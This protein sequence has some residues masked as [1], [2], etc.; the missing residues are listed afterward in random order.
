MTFEVEVAGRARQVTVEPLGTT[1]GSGGRFRVLLDGVAH[2]VDAR[3]TDLGWSIVYGDEQRSVDVAVTEQPRGQVLVQFPHIDVAVG[4]DGRR[5]RGDPL[6]A[7]HSTHEAGVAAPM[8]GRVVRVLV[9]P[10]DE[11]AP[12]QGLVVVEAMKMEN[13][14]AAPRAG[15]VAEVL[16][17]EGQSVDAGRLLVRLEETG[18]LKT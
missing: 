1:D 15:R 13:E 4:V 5:F 17:V 2:V 6:D 7:S 8:P 10:G 9:K 11:V 16:V 3:R 18:F 14:L 12:R